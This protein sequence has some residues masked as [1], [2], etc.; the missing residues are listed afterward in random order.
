MLPHPPI[1]SFNNSYGTEMKPITDS[2][3]ESSSGPF[4][5]PKELSL[6]VS[7]SQHPV[8][9]V[10]T[11]K[12]SE[13]E[14]IPTSLNSRLNQ[15]IVFSTSDEQ[16]F[17]PTTSNFPHKADTPNTEFTSPSKSIKG[18]FRNRMSAHSIESISE[19]PELRGRDDRRHS[20][21]SKESSP[22]KSPTRSNYLLRPLFLRSKSST[23]S[24]PLDMGSA[25]QISLTKESKVTL[26]D[27]AD[28]SSSDEASDD[29]RQDTDSINSILE[30]YRA[31]D[32]K[33]FKD[34]A[35]DHDKHQ[36]F[37]FKEEFDESNSSEI[38]DTSKQP[39]V[40]TPQY[41][42]RPKSQVISPS[43]SQ[44]IT[45]TKSHFETLV[46]VR[47]PSISRSGSTK[48][49]HQPIDTTLANVEGGLPLKRNSGASSNDSFIEKRSG[50]TS[51]TSMNFKINQDRI[52]PIGRSNSKNLRDRAKVISASSNVDVNRSAYNITGG[53]LDYE[54]DVKYPEPNIS[55]TPTPLQTPRRQNP[56][57][58]PTSS[59]SGNTRQSTRSD[60]IDENA[61]LVSKGP[62]RESIE[63]KNVD[64][65]AENIETAL[66]HE[67]LRLLEINFDETVLK[68][69]ST[70]S[71]NE[72]MR[73]SMSSG[74]L[75]HKLENF[76]EKKEKAGPKNFS[77]SSP[78]SS[79]M[80]KFN[81]QTSSTLRDSQGDKKSA[82]GNLTAGIDS[83][84][85]LPVML[86]S[87]HDRDYDEG[88]QRWSVYEHRANG[89]SL[90]Q[91]RT[92]HQNS[93]SEDTTDSMYHDAPAPPTL[94][95]PAPVSAGVP[96]P[97]NPQTPKHVYI[98]ESASLSQHSFNSLSSN[99]RA[100]PTTANTGS[101]RVTSTNQ[102][103]ID[104]NFN[105]HIGDFRHDKP[106][107]VAT[108]PST[109][110]LSPAFPH[111][112]VVVDRLNNQPSDHSNSAG[113]TQSHDSI[114]S[115]D[116][117][118]LGEFEKQIGDTNK[119]RTNNEDSARF[120]SYPKF[121]LLILIGLIVPPIFFLLTL[122]VFDTSNPS[123][124]SGLSYYKGDL[125]KKFSKTQKIISL[126]IGLLWFSVVIAMIGVGIGLGIR[127]S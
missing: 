83:S 50:E 82:L 84:S 33:Y 94:Q 58:N 78:R 108:K 97:K 37:L 114:Y 26:D 76:Y 6:D 39:E 7:D 8:F 55:G 29:Y 40:P 112:A 2:K 31:R 53:S 122:G 107:S 101:T 23:S 87:V 43:K 126:I 5:R 106:R 62:I 99:T 125:G 49:T 13:S 115:Q 56:R 109:G 105:K 17:T 54:S 44:V 63:V 110:S 85:E 34:P 69:N 25:L 24:I 61:S 18:F 79:N 64:M 118:D 41:A 30:E 73:S 77:N 68:H 72:T 81:P 67:S 9:E 70:L 89:P 123:N 98:A 75:L 10:V 11:Q 3:Q 27:F 88:N 111:N 46:L 103:Y 52:E 36:S 57:S 117:F 71:I 59:N 38:L 96:V 102:D 121:L 16:I 100:N 92:R 47:P 35:P 104:R 21:L 80:T 4:D 20:K 15:R 119:D 1:H 51:A 120:Y 66:K 95:A 12:V 124:H 48:Q 32:S 45:P 60:P 74:E 90:E 86:Y 28:T 65:L 91:G 93:S 22:T 14:S 113:R 116:S 19:E 127:E 42:T